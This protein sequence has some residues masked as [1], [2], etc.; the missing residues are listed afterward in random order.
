MMELELHISTING[1][2]DEVNLILQDN[3]INVNWMDPEN[4]GRSALSLACVNNHPKITSILLAH[5][6]IDVNQKNAL[7]FTPFATT[8]SRGNLACARLLLEDQRVKLNEPADRTT[9][10]LCIAYYGR[11]EILKYWIT[12]GR[13]MDLGESGNL[14]NDSIKKAKF[15]KH[16]EVLSIL[17]KVRDCPDDIRN[18]IRIELGWYHE[19]AAKHFSLLIFLCD[20]LLG[21]KGDDNS[22]TGRFFKIAKKLP[23][24]IQMI[25]CQRL[26]GSMLENIPFEFRESEFKKLAKLLLE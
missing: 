2:E 13:E 7:G 10:L 21:I 6:E 17:E 20:G 23:L 4:N 12:S 8:C 22:K 15:R 25:L 11:L 18:E 24:E 16:V 26:A 5:P 9:P 14:I 3:S 19:K 1:D